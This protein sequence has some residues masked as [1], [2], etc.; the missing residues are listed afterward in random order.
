MCFV[1][2]CFSG[3]KNCGLIGLPDVVVL[4]AHIFYQLKHQLTNYTPVY[5]IKFYHFPYFV[6]LT[7][8]NLYNYPFRY[9]VSNKNTH[10]ADFETCVFRVYLRN[11]FSHKKVFNI[12]L[13]PCL[14]SFQIKKKRIFEIRSQ[15]QLIFALTLFCQKK[16]N[17]SEKIRHFISKSARCIFLLLTV[18]AFWVSE[19]KVRG[20]QCKAEE[21][22]ARLRKIVRGKGR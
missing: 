4:L 13:H 17:L 18:K 3:E 6:E 9:A 12:Y 1:S 8:K 5:T 21:G 19:G 11:Q 7:E 15:N 2:L 10:L 16:S 14:K 22:C 20:R